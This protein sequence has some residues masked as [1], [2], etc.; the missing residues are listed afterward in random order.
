MAGLTMSYGDDEKDT[1]QVWMGIN[2]A[3]I[4]HSV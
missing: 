1:Y 3:S 4:P 2:K